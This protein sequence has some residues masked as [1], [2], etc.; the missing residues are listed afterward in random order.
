MRHAKRERET[1]VLFGKIFVVVRFFATQIKLKATRGGYAR[2]PVDF[3]LSLFLSLTRSL[4]AHKSKS[5]F[6][7]TQTR[8]NERKRKRIKYAA[9]KRCQKRVNDSLS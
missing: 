7:R 3:S 6:T 1:T 5:E 8:E 4:S 2:A 9:E